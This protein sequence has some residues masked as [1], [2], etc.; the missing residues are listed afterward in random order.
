M[1]E[2]TYKCQDC[3]A[4]FQAKQGSRQRFC[5]PCMYKRILHTETRG[6][7]GRKLTP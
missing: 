6:K 7:K 1:N 4:E 5:Q 3:G 2:T